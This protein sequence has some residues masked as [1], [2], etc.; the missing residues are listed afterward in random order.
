M[1]QTH[2]LKN[3][4]VDIPSGK[5]IVITGVSGSGKSSLALDTL[6]MLKVKEDTWSPFFHIRKAIFGQD[7]KT[8]CGLH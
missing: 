1:Y 6:F 3:L 8:G 4:N 2:N 5:Y 7:G